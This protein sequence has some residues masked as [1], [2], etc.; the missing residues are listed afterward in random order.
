[1]KKKVFTFTLDVNCPSTPLPLSSTAGFF[2]SPCHPFLL[3]QSLPHAFLSLFRLFNFPQ[4]FC[5][6]LLLFLTFFPSLWLSPAFS[7]YLVSLLTQMIFS[8]LS[9][10]PPQFY[11]FSS[12]FLPCLPL[13]LFSVLLLYDSPL[14][15]PLPLSVSFLQLFLSYCLSP[16]CIYESVQ[17]TDS[18]LQCRCVSQHPKS[19]FFNLG[20]SLHHSDLV[21]TRQLYSNN[22][23]DVDELTNK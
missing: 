7:L 2:P 3:K 15:P 9:V 1:M 4:S 20:P 18:S 13:F 14:P 6:T 19:L 16:L 5:L 8:H 22:G 23:A 12:S 21:V 17:I 10:S 11:I